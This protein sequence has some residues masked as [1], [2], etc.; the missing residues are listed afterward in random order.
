MI[1]WEYT[2]PFSVTGPD[3]TVIPA[4]T[5]LGPTITG[6]SLVDQGFFW[7]NKVRTY[8]SHGATF[9]VGLYQETTAMTLTPEQLAAFITW[10]TDQGWEEPT[11]N[12][13]I[14]AA[15]AEAA[16]EAATETAPEMA[17]GDPAANAQVMAART[18]LA[19]ACKTGVATK[20]QAAQRAY[21]AA[22]A[23]VGKRPG[24][25]GSSKHP[26]AALLASATQAR[27]KAPQT[28]T[29]ASSSAAYSALEDQLRA[30]KEITDQLMMKELDREGLLV[31]I[32]DP[33]ELYSAAPDYFMK[34]VSAN[35]SL[36]GA[37]SPSS[38][39]RSGLREVSQG[40]DEGEKD[41]VAIQAYR[42]QQVKLGRKLTYTQAMNEWE[43]AHDAKK[44]T[45]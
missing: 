33:M 17:A 7:M 29:T 37:K 2:L 14:A 36:V 6:L 44:V 11:I 40:D 27:A 20:I 12:A 43:D 24:P 35:V 39:G 28:P 19:V 21:A 15:T 38:S 23:K 30:Q 9:W 16:A 3:G 8:S 34:K 13:M 45:R 26:L 25:I 1:E 31:G 41:H 32:D 4:G 42:A 10:A 5:F 22:L 18:A